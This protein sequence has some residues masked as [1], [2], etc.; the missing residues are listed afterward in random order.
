MIKL[1]RHQRRASKK[2]KTEAELLATC[3]A[4]ARWLL[5][6]SHNDGPKHNAL[7]L[8]STPKRAALSDAR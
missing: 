5:S 8:R 6:G 4:H 1:N 3:A 7:V 2:A